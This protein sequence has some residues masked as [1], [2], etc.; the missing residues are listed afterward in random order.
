MKFGGVGGQRKR[1]RVYR[2]RKMEGEGIGINGEHDGLE[3]WVWA[4]Q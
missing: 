3:S 2:K 4:M 1:E